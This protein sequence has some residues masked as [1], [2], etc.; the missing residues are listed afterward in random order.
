MF[1]TET[2]T[3]RCADIVLLTACLPKVTRYIAT[4]RIKTIQYAVIWL[5][6]YVLLPYCVWS[7]GTD[8]NWTQSGTIHYVPEQASNLCFQ[9]SRFNQVLLLSRIKFLRHFMLKQ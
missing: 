4:R 9:G 3:T 6:G 1:I 2:R 7:F 5:F 8:D